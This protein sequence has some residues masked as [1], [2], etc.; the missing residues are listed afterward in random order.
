MSFSAEMSEVFAR[1]GNPRR[2][3]KDN[4]DEKQ[5]GGI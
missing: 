2:F 5:Q 1:K 3:R 4:N